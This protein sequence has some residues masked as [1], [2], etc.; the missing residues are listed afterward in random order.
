MIEGFYSVV[1]KTPIGMGGGTLYLQNGNAYGGDSTM[2]YTGT[3]S[4]E[5][6]EM[7]AAIHMGTHLVIPGHMS[8]FGVP[9]ADLSVVGLVGPNGIISGRATSPQ[10]PGITMEFTMKNISV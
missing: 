10:A 1:F 3:Y 2:Y 4:A 5:N 8:V 6:D 9:K 7:K